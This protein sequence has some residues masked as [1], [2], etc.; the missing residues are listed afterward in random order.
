MFSVSV[1][2]FV[3]RKEALYTEQP[4]YISNS[5]ATNCILECATWTYHRSPIFYGKIK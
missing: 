5:K 3:K 1:V 4:T 2:V